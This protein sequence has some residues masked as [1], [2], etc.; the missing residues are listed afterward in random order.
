MDPRPPLLQRLT[1]GQLLAADVVLAVPLAAL[2]RPTGTQLDRAGL[3]AAGWYAIAATL[4]AAV[5]IRRVG[6]WPA[7]ALAVA[8]FLGASW[9]GFDKS[10]T[11][12]LALVLYTLGAARPRREAVAG[13]AAALACLG[14]CVALAEPAPRL[15]DGSALDLLAGH[16]LLLAGAWAAGQM[17]RARRAYEAGLSEQAER[18][19]RAE[20]TR[21]R[22]GI[23]RE[24]HDVV[25]HSMSVIAVQA[26]VGH[27]VIARHPDE[28]ARSLATIETTSRATLREMRVL[29]GVLRE[30]APPADGDGLRTAPGLAGLAALV[31]RTGQAGLTVDLRVQGEPRPL[32]RGVDLAGYRIVQEALTNVVKHAATGT[33]RARVRYRPDGVE[34][35]VTDAGR[36]SP[37]GSV[38]SGH[39]L[40]GMRERAALYGGEFAAGPLPAGGFRVWARIPAGELP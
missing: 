3:P 12:A 1:L 24:L 14:C 29:L 27:H 19:A 37:G 21:E 4:A 30:E 38:P 6:S 17:T 15:R 23:A 5:V 34:I 26:G 13:L 9:Y 39:G 8:G 7:L 2:Y 18:R 31:E 11:V 40:V 10:P 36:G 35:E 16:G 25:A 22:L 33:A 32:P 20:L 28:A